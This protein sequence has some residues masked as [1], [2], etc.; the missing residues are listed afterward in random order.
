MFAMFY[1]NNEVTT[2]TNHPHYIPMELSIV[3]IK[4]LKFMFVTRL[5]VMTTF[6]L[7]HKKFCAWPYLDRMSQLASV[8]ILQYLLLYTWY[9]IVAQFF[10]HFTWSSFIHYFPCPLLL[11]YVLHIP[12]PN[13]VNP[14]IFCSWTLCPSIGLENDCHEQTYNLSHFG[15]PHYYP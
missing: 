10:N 11:A 14:M 1:W 15:V 13:L 7:F 3:A 4:P 9:T 2:T 5:F 6:S 8:N 12:H